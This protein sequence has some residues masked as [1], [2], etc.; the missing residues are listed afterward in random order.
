M[1]FITL[2]FVLCSLRCD[3]EYQ[4]MYCK[5]RLRIETVKQIK[6]WG[7][8]KLWKF[9]EW[10][11]LKKINYLIFNVISDDINSALMRR[12]CHIQSVEIEVFKS[13]VSFQFTSEKKSDLKEVEITLKYWALK[14]PQNATFSRNFFFSW[15]LKENK[16][17]KFNK[18]VKF[19][20]QFQHIEYDMIRALNKTLL[21]Y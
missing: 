7:S 20:H 1:W 10:N 13:W 4:I 9:L 16:D 17:S 14:L 6:I 2:I 3:R 21:W 11:D 18:N 12:S 8:R 19:R 5:T 15:K